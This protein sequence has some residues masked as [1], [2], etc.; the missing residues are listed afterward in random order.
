MNNKILYICISFLGTAPLTLQ[1]LT[2]PQEMRELCGKAQELE[3]KINKLKTEINLFLQKERISTPLIKNIYDILT[4]CFTVL[5]DIQR[6]SNLLALGQADTRNDFVKCS[7]VIKNFVSYFKSVSS[8]L[9]KAGAEISKLREN[10]QLSQSELK[11]ALSKYEKLCQEIETK[12]NELALTRVENIIQDDVVCHLATKSESLDELDAELEAENTIG[13][14]KNTKVST[15][16]VIAYPVAGKIANEFGDKGANNE[17]LYYT[18][19]EAPPDA[20]VT[21]PAKGVV[22]FSEKFLTY[23][24]ILIISNGEYRVFLYGM[25]VLFASTGDVVEIGDYVGRMKAKTS[26]PPVIKMELKKSGEHLDP[27]QWMKA[28]EKIEKKQ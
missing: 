7:I 8:Q 17:M 24:N 23:G 27:R 10:K 26:D 11:S 21:S 1:A 6:F 28:A 2:Q 15:E 18:S 25:D 4:R 12:A 20:I 9:G 16:L 5:L 3:K 22:V 14:L 13:V 19:F